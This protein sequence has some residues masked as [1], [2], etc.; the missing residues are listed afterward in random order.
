MATWG[1]L[2]VVKF[3]CFYWFARTWKVNQT[4]ELHKKYQFSANGMEIFTDGLQ[5]VQ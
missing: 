2:G 4:N 3:D 1:L 5:I